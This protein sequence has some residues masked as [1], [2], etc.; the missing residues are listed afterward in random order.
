MRPS[1]QQIHHSTDFDMNVHAVDSEMFTLPPFV[2]GADSTTD[3]YT[4]SA[5]SPLQQQQ[6]PQ[7]QQQQRPSSA[8]GGLWGT[9]LQ[10]A[11][12]YSNF[13]FSDPS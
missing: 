10:T 6:P 8:A 7:Q 11:H 5:T 12:H 13:E 9:S 1:Q 2:P 3:G 4:P